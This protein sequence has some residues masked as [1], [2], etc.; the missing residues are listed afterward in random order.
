MGIICDMVRLSGH[1]GPFQ[2]ISSDTQ[3][4]RKVHD[5][6]RIMVRGWVKL[7]MGPQKPLADHCGEANCGQTKCCGQSIVPTG[8]IQWV[9]LMLWTSWHPTTTVQ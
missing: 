7:S 6:R 1:S 8:A 9:T 5:G 2:S 4:G 3:T